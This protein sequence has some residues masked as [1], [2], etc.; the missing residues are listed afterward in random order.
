M[1]NTNKSFTEM[2]T[3]LEHAN[4]L[5]FGDNVPMVQHPEYFA[6][7]YGDYSL[8]GYAVH[9]TLDGGLF[10]SAPLQYP[11]GKWGRSVS[12]SWRTNQ[13][14]PEVNIRVAHDIFS[15]SVGRYEDTDTEKLEK[16]FQ[17]M[18]EAMSDL[19]G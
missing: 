2:A 7:Y 17:L 19:H 16:A 18:Q 1:Y 12:L 13:E 6:M 4:R 10:I 11:D 8:T 3:I 9:I 15:T 5:V 14:Y